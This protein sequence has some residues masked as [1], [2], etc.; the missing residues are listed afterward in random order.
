MK[1]QNFLTLIKKTYFL[2]YFILMSSIGFTQYTLE[3]KVV[4]DPRMPNDHLGHFGGNSIHGD[5][6]VA[7][8]HLVSFGVSTCGAAFLYHWNDETC[9]WDQIDIIY[10]QSAV[11]VF[12]LES[13]SNFGAAVALEND[14]IAIGAPGAT[15]EGLDEAGKVYIYRIIS[16]EAVFVEI[17]QPRRNDA[18]FDGEPFAMF[19][20]SLKL[21]GQQLIVGAPRETQNDA[22]VAIE[23]AGAAY[24]YRWNTFSSTFL[25]ENKLSAP[26]RNVLDRFGHEVSIFGN[27][28]VVAAQLEDEDELESSFME[29]AGSVYVY[30]QEMSGDWVFSQK[31]VAFDRSTEDNFGSSVDMTQQHIVVGAWVEDENVLGGSP[32]SGAGSAYIYEWNL[33]DNFDFEQKIVASDRAVDD[34]FGFLVAISDNNILVGAPNQDLNAVG[35]VPLADAG[36]TYLFEHAGGV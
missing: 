26:V 15:N 35:A 9:V 18:F 19:G 12:D 36:A 21:H 6:M 3:A 34:N 22:L 5:Y 28:A 25:F 17:L 16:G 33:V 23:G 24:I 29:N 13:G 2:I 14:L 11:G 10:A 20:N 7:G 1:S 30:R 4:G 32:M 8:A 31:I 27:Y